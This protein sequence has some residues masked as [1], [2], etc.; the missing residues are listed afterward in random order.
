MEQ[1]RS[2]VS[3]IF[4]PAVSSEQKV[5]Q[6]GVEGGNVTSR[7]FLAIQDVIASRWF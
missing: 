6:A 5:V 2:K 7:K 3:I 4:A 1:G